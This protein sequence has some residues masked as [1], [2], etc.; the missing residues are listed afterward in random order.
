VTV[1][2]GQSTAHRL[3][4]ESRE[5]GVQFG[6]VLSWYA[7]ER[8]VHRLQQS[9][10]RERLL[11]DGDLLVHGFTGKVSPLEWRASLRWRSEA[12]NASLSAA[13]SDVCAT[14]GG[15]A[16]E[17]EADVAVAEAGTS[18]LRARQFEAVATAKLRSF[19]CL[20]PISLYVSEDEYPRF[21]PRDTSFARLIETD[22]ATRPMSSAPELFFAR[23]V[24][25]LWSTGI[26]HLSP[27][28]Y[29]DLHRLVSSGAMIDSTV[30]KALSEV[31]IAS[32]AVPPRMPLALTTQASSDNDLRQIWRAFQKRIR[33]P[34]AD[35]TSVLDGLRR[36]AFPLLDAARNDVAS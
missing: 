5:R 11:L 33:V 3:L 28:I 29:L 13:L 36:Y 34:E 2:V 30:V 8:F 32:G 24:R 10:H 31:F 21:A 12:L 16:I 14:D 4:H 26:A 6:L 19:D 17:F 35:L 15:D 20:V 23:R 9:G 25:D 22:L 27:Q 18:N 7:V 1:A